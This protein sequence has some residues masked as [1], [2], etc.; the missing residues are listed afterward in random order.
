MPETLDDLLVS[1]EAEDDSNE[2]VDSMNAVANVG[3]FLS[4]SMNVS[5]GAQIR[6]TQTNLDLVRSIRAKRDAKREMNRWKRRHTELDIEQAKLN[7][8]LIE[9]QRLLTAQGN[10]FLDIQQANL[11]KKKALRDVQVAQFAAN[12]KHRKMNENAFDAELQGNIALHQARLTQIQLG[13]EIGVLI[14]SITTLVAARWAWI[15]AHLTAEGIATLGT[16]AVIGAVI[17]ASSIVAVNVLTPEMPEAPGGQT[18]VG[19]VRRIKKGGPMFVHSGEDIGTITEETNDVMV[20]INTPNIGAE[21][22]IGMENI[23]SEV[24]ASG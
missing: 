19:Q 12:D 14:T 23:F 13:M 5:M 4:R 9:R 22:F 20:N 15:T 16:A 24:F 18:E 6:L 2:L 10:V 7:V 1:L 11:D 8:K 21:S 3:Q 17:V